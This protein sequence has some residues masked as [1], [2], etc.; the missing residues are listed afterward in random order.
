MKKHLVMLV[1]L[2]L[3]VSALDLHAQNLGFVITNGLSAAY[4]VAVDTNNDYYITDSDRNSI[5][6]YHPITGDLG[7]LAGAED[8]SPGAA[9]G[10]GI[11][12]SFS[13][14]QGIVF[15]PARNGLV[16]ADGGNNLIRLVALDGTVTTLAGSGAVG[17]ADGAGAAAQ[18]NDP[19]GL[20]IDTAGNIYIADLGNGV[21]RKLDPANTVTTIATNGVSVKFNRPAAVAVDNGTGDLYVTDTGNNAIDVIAAGVV[22][23]IAGSGSPIIYGATDRLIGT[24]ATFLHPRGL[25]W[26]GG[27]AGLLVC[28]TDNGVIRR[29]YPNASL[30]AGTYSVETYATNAALAKPIGITK[31][32][33]GNFPIADEG[34]G[35]TSPSKL[36]IISTGKALPPVTAPEIASLNLTNDVQSGTVAISLDQITG[37]ATFN[38]DV[39]IGVWTADANPGVLTY[40]TLGPTTNEPPPPTQTAGSTPPS[41]RLVD[42]FLPP[43]IINPTQPDV[44][45]QAYS[46]AQGRI[47]SAVVTARVQ[48]QCATPTIVGTDPSSFTLTEITKSARLRYTTDGSPPNDTSSPLYT[49]GAVLNVVNGTNNVT[50]SVTAFR[51]GYSPSTTVTHVFHFT[52]IQNSFVGITHDLTAGIGST[53]LVPIDVKL[54]STNVLQSVQFRVETTPVGGAPAVSTQMRNVMITTNDFVQLPPPA[55]N[56]PV[57]STYQNGATTGVQIAYLGQNT[58]FKASGTM[59]IALVAVPI[60]TTAAAGNQYTIA[61]VQPSG[62]SD[63]AQTALALAPFASHVITVTNIPYTVGDSAPGASYNAGGFGNGNLNNNDVNNALAASLG[64]HVPF[65]FSDAFDAMDAFPIDTPTSVGGDGQIRFL[66]WQII[67][68]RSLGLDTNNWTR[69]WSTGGLRVNSRATLNGAPDLPAES[70]SADSSA[71]LRLTAQNLAVQAGVGA[72]STTAAAGGTAQVPIYVTVAPGSALAGMEFRAV[73]QPLNGAPALTQPAQFIPAQG[74]PVPQAPPLPPNQAGGGWPLPMGS[75]SSS[76]TFSSSLTGSNVLGIVTFTVPAAAQ[77]SQ[78]YSVTVANADGAPD[79]N[80]QYTFTSGTAFVAVGAPPPA[81]VA[82]ADTTLQL[83][84]PGAAGSSYVVEESADLTRWTTVAT[85]AGRGAT[86]QFSDPDSSGKARFYRVRSQ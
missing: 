83:S 69:M 72:N 17:T 33:N 71:G 29:V 50:F 5:L 6:R 8:G 75:G 46:T 25:L 32:A 48:F 22:T 56:A 81:S 23:R 65:S 44:T 80:T 37:T 42:S 36:W 84:W 57:S 26:A 16:V 85:L 40:Y 34:T 54:N 12:A 24:D 68:Q 1:I 38:N 11:F 4:G 43:T 35:T 55:T 20:A 76:D 15:S 45:I 9:N 13:N 10:K 18:F 77:D 73:V 31:D 52:D 63:G 66:D 28:D 86:L 78:V 64:L 61:C 74:V 49:S 7:S 2:A 70:S 41:F 14:P 62:T 51:D 60:P 53:I 19:A 59:T 47:P 82:P 30:P 21:I 79:I 3:G 27:T 39:V 67:L 58:G